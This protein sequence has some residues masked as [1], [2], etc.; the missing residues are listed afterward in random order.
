[1]FWDTDVCIRFMRGEVVA[2]SYPSR[3]YI[4]SVTL[5][6]LET[7]VNKCDQPTKERAKLS[8]LMH[9]VRVRAFGRRQARCYGSIRAGLESEGQGIGKMDMLIAAHAV[10]M[11]MPL[12]THNIREFR[13][14]RGLVV[15]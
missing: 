8:F 12:L 2:A 9:R 4:S 13:R 11:G 6:E 14:V 15:V 10:S 3:A 7:G 1:M 5:A